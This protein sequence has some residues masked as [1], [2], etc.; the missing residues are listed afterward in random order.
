MANLMK[1]HF[2]VKKKRI[3]EFS[4]GRLAF[5]M[6]N[7]ARYTSALTLAS[8]LKRYFWLRANLIETEAAGSGERRTCNVE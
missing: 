7:P 2:H 3:G 1:R 6:E 4:G 5:D 8:K